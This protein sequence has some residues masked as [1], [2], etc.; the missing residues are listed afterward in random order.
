MFGSTSDCY[1]VETALSI[2]SRSGGTPLKR[3]VFQEFFFEVVVLARVRI[4]GGSSQ[5]AS[6]YRL[7]L[8]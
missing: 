7:N 4:V 2:D 1:I 5:G 8:T 6:S 3:N